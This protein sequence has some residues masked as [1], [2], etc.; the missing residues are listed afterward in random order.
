L[1]MGIDLMQECAENPAGA[2][3]YVVDY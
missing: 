3:G 2:G 1:F